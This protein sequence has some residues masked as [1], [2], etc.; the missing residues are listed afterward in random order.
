[1]DAIRAHLLHAPRDGLLLPAAA[2]L[3]LAA[4]GALT[5]GAYFVHPFALPALAVAAAF[6]AAVLARPALGVAGAL[7]A[8]PLEA[9]ALPLPSGALSPAEGA[10]VLVGLGWVL[11]FLF[12]TD[13]VAK[14]GARDLPF[15]LLLIAVA[16]G[17][18]V[19]VEPA[20]V[21]RVS[22]IWALFYL[23]YL[24]V[25]S[26]TEREVRLVVVAAAAGAGILGA[27]GAA[28]Y[29]QSGGTK[30]FAG[31]ALTAE[32]EAGTFVDTNYYAA[33]LTLAL[34]PGI[35][36]LL[37]DVRRY[38]WLSLPLAAGVAG[39]VFSLS[40]GGILGFGVGLLVLLAWARARHVAVVLVA[41]VVVLTV[42]GANPVVSS[43][44]FGT[45]E[46]RL[47]T[48]RH[49]T[50]ESKRPQIWSTAVDVTVEHPFV[51]VGVNQFKH[52][53]VQRLLYERG[54]PLENAH[55]VPLS[56][57]AETGLLGLTGFLAFLGVI[58]MLAA[59]ALH[60]VDRLRASIALGL[61]AGIGGFMVQGLTAAL[62][63]VPILMGVLFLWAGLL[64]ALAKDAKRPARAGG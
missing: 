44:Y 33:F 39:L 41:V 34:L 64:A 29:L 1:M 59:R 49:P 12:Y 4:A 53:S 40:R 61:A 19:A 28:S 13:T 54:R 25:Q 48:I 8:T 63:R 50:R 46:Q 42:A 22:A 30:L 14:P 31:G 26:F 2:A 10:L 51:G 55:S 17:V 57:A 47:S 58:G 35:A 15:A 20:P 60:S 37:A 52:E 23:A 6:V 21:L 32:R 24:Q 11:R 3:G 36:L 62:V 7:L 43:E 9:V 56:L 18:A 38:W 16:C 45:V 27:I 5:A